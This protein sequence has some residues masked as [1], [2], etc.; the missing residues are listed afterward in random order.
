MLL[1]KPDNKVRVLIN[2][3][4]KMKLFSIL[5]AK[6]DFRKISEKDFRNLKY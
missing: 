1:L 2:I 4:I 5:S 3:F 6:D